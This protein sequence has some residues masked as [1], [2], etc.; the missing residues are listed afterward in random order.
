MRFK[1]MWNGPAALVR[2]RSALLV[3]FSK[4]LIPTFS[5]IS[6][7]GW[8]EGQ[9]HTSLNRTH[10]VRSEQINANISIGQISLPCDVFIHLLNP[11]Q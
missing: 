6:G 1:L 11:S 2:L 9:F 3:L 5:R 10:L 8:G 4:A 7:R